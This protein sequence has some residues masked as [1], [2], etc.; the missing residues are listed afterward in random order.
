MYIFVK[1]TNSPWIQLHE[2]MRSGAKNIIWPIVA[3]WELQLYGYQLR[4]KITQT[5]K[6][7]ANTVGLFIV[8]SHPCS[9]RLGLNYIWFEIDNSPLRQQ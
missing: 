1:R 7:I 6:K 2:A 8:S 9:R 5:Q 4:R 3:F